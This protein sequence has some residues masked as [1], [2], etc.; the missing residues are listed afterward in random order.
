MVV[1]V[2]ENRLVLEGPPTPVSRY[3]LSVDTRFDDV[4][5]S[6]LHYTAA[7]GCTGGQVLVFT[8]H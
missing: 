1:M 2:M 3:R 5:M 6:P 4:V 7:V 8:L